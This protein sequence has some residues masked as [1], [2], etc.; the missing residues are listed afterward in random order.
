MR[1]AT[2]KWILVVM[3]LAMAGGEFRGQ[4]TVNSDK[5]LPIQEGGVWGVMER[6]GKV[7]L[8]P[9]YDE[10]WISEGTIV[11]WG[12]QGGGPRYLTRNI[13]FI[14]K[15]PDLPDLEDEDLRELPNSLG[16]FQE[17]LAKVVVGGL[18]GFINKAG[19]YAAKPEFLRARDFSEGLAAVKNDT[20]LWGYIGKDGVYVI[21][22]E[23]SMASSF[24][25]GLAA[26]T[27]RDWERG[28][29]DRAGKFVIKAQ[30][31][32]VADFS[33]GLAAVA[34]RD[35]G[36]E[37][38]PGILGTASFK[39]KWG[40]V[41]KSGAM[42]I[43][44]Q[45][46]EVYPFYEGLAAVKQGGKWGFVDKT[47]KMLASP[48]FEQASVFREGLAVVKLGGKWGYIDRKGTMLISPRFDD[49]WG[50]SEGL[51]AVNQGG[52][53]GF[54]DPTGKMIINPQF[55]KVWG[56]SEGL[57]AVWLN[58]KMGYITKTGEYFWRASK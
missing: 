32:M 44:P 22:P 1:R 20:G 54:I 49:A 52:K 45:F 36:E 30:F 14:W 50:F 58:K 12:G 16:R 8:P 39:G 7:I 43:S 6:S 38:L 29:I 19:K 41:D 35:P 47:G 56:F 57:A 2:V 11:V 10:V 51:A 17:G 27:T 46:E 4:G 24:R 28:Y 33:E 26:V 42:A 3:A 31:A 34:V 21:N 53:W 55:E 25:E 37:P 15:P 18:F 5:L 48:Q 9:L 40:Y 13:E 23:F